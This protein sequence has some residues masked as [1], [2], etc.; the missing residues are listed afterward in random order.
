MSRKARRKA[1]EKA[2]EKMPHRNPVRVP[3]RGPPCPDPHRNGFSGM[4]APHFH[5]ADLAYAKIVLHALKYPHQTVNGVLLGSTST[6]GTTVSI[7]DA[8]PLQHHWTNLS[9]MMEVGL[10]LVRSP[11]FHHFPSPASTESVCFA[12]N[13]GVGG[14]SCPQ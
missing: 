7:V 6:P 8:V 3:L 14:Q 10:G 2:Q 4:S 9:P 13:P 12:R 11:P 5:I 1:H